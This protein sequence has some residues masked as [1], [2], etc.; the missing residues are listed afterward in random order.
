MTCSMLLLEISFVNFRDHYLEYLT[1]I[2]QESHLD[3]VEIMTKPQL[4][5]FCRSYKL[6]VT[7]DSNEQ[8]LRQVSSLV[9][10]FKFYMHLY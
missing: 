9:F 8:K 6:V 7:N 10:E 2:C 5:S 1:L 3:P 4:L